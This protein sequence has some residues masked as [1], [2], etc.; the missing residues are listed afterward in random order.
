MGENE[1]E[2]GTAPA[3]RVDIIELRFLTGIGSIEARWGIPSMMDA[4]SLRGM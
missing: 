4:L 1:G 2:G 3:E